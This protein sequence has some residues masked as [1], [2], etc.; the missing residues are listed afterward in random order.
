MN[1]ERPLILHMY[2]DRG[3]LVLTPTAVLACAVSRLLAG[4]RG[5]EAELA[6]GEEELTALSQ[7]PLLG[8]PRVRLV[9]GDPVPPDHELCDEGD[10]EAAVRVRIELVRREGV[11]LEL[12]VVEPRGL[13]LR[14]EGLWQRWMREVPVLGS[15]DA[16][17]ASKIGCV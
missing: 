10:E 4:A 9:F 5:G 14:R 17:R 7:L 6:T 12:D 2:N 11:A 3:A 13:E 16:L 8:F 15:Q 1:R